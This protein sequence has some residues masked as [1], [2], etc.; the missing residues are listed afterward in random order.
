MGKKSKKN[1]NSNLINSVSEINARMNFLYQASNLLTLTTKI[2]NQKSKELNTSNNQNNNENK[3][4]ISNMK[5]EMLSHQSI[6]KT[7]K[8][9]ISTS[10]QQRNQDVIKKNLSINSNKSS[11]NKN[12]K[13]SKRI[14]LKQ[15]KRLY[16]ENNI[17]LKKSLENK[18]SE[19]DNE[20]N[21]KNIKENDNVLLK[22]SLI[23]ISRYYNNILQ[24][25]SRKTV[26]RM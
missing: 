26:S 14:S 5:V 20:I 6:E 1:G 19:N 8:N 21:N 11:I 17:H 24:V 3:D 16:L 22:H 12:Q 13:K 9:I 18:S 7:P 25:I 4:K 23:P 15:K 2:H 10:L